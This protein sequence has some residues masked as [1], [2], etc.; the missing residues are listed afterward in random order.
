MGNICARPE[1]KEPTIERQNSQPYKINSTIRT[2]AP[3]QTTA[4]S[5]RSARLRSS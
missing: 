1:D 4:R 2:S 5:R 3:T